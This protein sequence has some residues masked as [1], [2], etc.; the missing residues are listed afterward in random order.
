MPF[1]K[2]FLEVWRDAIQDARRINWYGAGGATAAGSIIIVGIALIAAG[3]MAAVYAAL[4]II[5]AV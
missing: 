4:W 3:L 5:G 1:I 2:G